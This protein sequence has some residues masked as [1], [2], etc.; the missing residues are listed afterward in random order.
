MGGGWSPGPLCEIA[1]RCPELQLY[2]PMIPMPPAGIRWLLN[3][4]LAMIVIFIFAI[5]PWLV[6][7]T[8]ALGIATSASL[9]RLVLALASCV[10]ILLLIVHLVRFAIWD[11]LRIAKAAIQSYE[12][13]VILAFSWG[14]GVA[15]WLLEDTQWTG[16]TILLAPT[17]RA[18][19]WASQQPL[20]RVPKSVHVFHAEYGA[21]CPASQHK[22]LE[23]MGCHMHLCRGD[24]HILMAKRSLEMILQCL[25]E[26]LSS[27]QQSAQEETQN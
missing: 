25:S 16:P 9:V 12:P 17:I 6:G 7:K 3:P 8:D 18:M 22:L 2:Q 24:G 21:F 26:L 1:A 20:P 11:S 15:C 27:C 4:Y 5:H 23:R 19:C 14:G 10:C 13:D